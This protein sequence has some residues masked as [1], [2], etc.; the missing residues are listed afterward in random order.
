MYIR[1][2]HDDVKSQCWNG[3]IMLMRAIVDVHCGRILKT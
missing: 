3:D 2:N 1:V